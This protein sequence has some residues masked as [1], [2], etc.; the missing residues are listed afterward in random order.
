[1]RHV[2]LDLDG[3]LVDPREGITSALRHAL[4]EMGAEVPPADEL[5][6]CIGPPLRQSLEVLLGPAA[7]I[8]EAVEHYRD[9][10]GE[11]GLS[12]AD[13]YDGVGEMLVDLRDAGATLYIATSKARIYAER[14]AEAF[15][16]DAWVEGIFGAELDGSLSDKGELL[17]YA[18]AET[19]AEPA[20]SLM[21]GDRAHDVEGAKLN[22][23]PVIGALWG[24]ADPDELRMADPDALAGTPEE[25]PEIALDLFGLSAD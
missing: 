16:I 19:K 15:G 2:F 7:D 1:M 23:I 20:E 6:W 11:I 4:G 12:E 17:A 21:L 24:Y 3:T 9:Y 25:V 13:L 14:V 10:Y 8:E 18:L 22:H 5:L